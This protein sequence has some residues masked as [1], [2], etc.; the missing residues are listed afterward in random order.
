MSQKNHK[1]TVENRIIVKWNFNSDN[2]HV[3]IPVNAFIYL[4]LDVFVG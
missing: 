1:R 2:T 4:S 3:Y